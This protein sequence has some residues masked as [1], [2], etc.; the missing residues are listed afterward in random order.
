MPFLGKVPSQIVD[1]D[2]DIDGGTIDG[3]T[4][5]SITAGAGTFTNLSATGTITFPDDGISGDDING[6]TI[7]N[8]TSTGI[9]DNATS[10]AI[11]ID[12]SQNVGIGT[13]SPSTPLANVSGSA[14][15]LTVEGAVPT[16][17]IKDTS[18]ADDVGYLY[19]NA[20]DLNI[21]NYAG[22]STIFSYGSSYTEAMRLDSSGNVGIGTASP[23]GVLAVTDGANGLIVGQSGENFYSGNTHRFFS[24]NYT[25]E[26][27]HI[28]SSGNLLVGTTSSS[29]KI[30][31]NNGGSGTGFYVLQD[32][33]GTNF[34]PVLIHN[35]YITGG[36]TGTLISFER[37]DGV[38][39]GSIRATTS[40][41]SYVTSSDYRLKENVVDL[42]NG[43]DRLKQIPVHRF[44]FIVD[45]DTTVDGFIAHEVQDVIPEAITGTK[46]GMTTE[47]YEVSPAVLDEE[48]NVVTD[49]V[50]GTRE[51]PE[52]QGIDQ[53]K[54][55]PL[56][57]AALQ[58]AVAKIEDLESRLSALEA[59]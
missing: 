48:G 53:S 33:S 26:H 42:D 51:V 57:T 55:E 58:E 52:Y 35:D 34:T 6:G 25:T 29:G 47:E 18:A 5:G 19:Q 1:S 56:L 37:G 12:S 36:N 44:N 13:S 28:N 10:T 41:T 40:T 24:Q 22:G 31:V 11:T 15:G 30:S 14:T 39:V 21:L 20:N 4:I 7:S 23:S 32:S 17:A 2:V 9:D 38:A 54:L 16:I 8:F 46:D 27:M 3:A 50:M 49:A 45:P 43:I 59:N